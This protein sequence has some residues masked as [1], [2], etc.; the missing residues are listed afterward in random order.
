MCMCIQVYTCISNV[1]VHMIDMGSYI[2][3]NTSPHYIDYSLAPTTSSTTCNSCSSGSSSSNN[4]SS[5]IANSNTSNSN[6][7]RH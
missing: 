6:T 3:K 7:S 1:D 4:C 2:H 5:S